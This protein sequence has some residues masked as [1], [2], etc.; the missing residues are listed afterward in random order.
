MSIS[1]FD[2]VFNKGLN[3]SDK[4]ERLLKRLKNIEDKSE[5]QQKM[6][7]NKKGDQLGINSAADI[8]YERLSPEGK[9]ILVKLTNQEKRINYRKLDFRRDNNLEFYFSDYRSL[10]E[11]SKAIYYRNLSIEEA[12]RMQEEFK[13][14][15]GALE[16]YNPENPEYVAAKSN[17]L[18]NA[19][20][21]CDGREEIINAFKNKIFPFKKEEFGSYDDDD[22]GKRPND[23]ES[24]D[25]F[26]TPKELE[27]IPELS[28]FENEEETPR[29]MPHLQN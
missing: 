20:N 12:E 9:T 29:N 15:L 13:G 18:I 3:E 5:D 22:F 19:K 11:L 24:N 17:L 16:K 26:Y 1:P 25:E 28:N 27:T 10:K 8:I 21:L 4:K 7:E 6:I 14:I 2:K 23:D